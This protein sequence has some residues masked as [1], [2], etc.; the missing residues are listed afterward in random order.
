MNVSRFTPTFRQHAITGQDL[1]NS[2]KNNMAAKA[3]LHAQKRKLERTKP[4]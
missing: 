3:Q 4:S 2:L 1:D